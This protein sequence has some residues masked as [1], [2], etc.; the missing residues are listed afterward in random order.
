MCC[1]LHF[2]S[3]QHWLHSYYYPPTPL[4]CPTHTSVSTTITNV[5]VSSAPESVTLPSLESCDEIETFTILL[6]DQNSFEGIYSIIRV[7][8]FLSDII[9]FAVFITMPLDILL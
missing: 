1:A 4:T 5:S 9:Y 8:T 3:L 7:L 2:R 6:V